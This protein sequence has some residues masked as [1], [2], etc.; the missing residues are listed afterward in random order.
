MGVTI[1]SKNQSIALSYFGFYRLRKKVAELINEDIA[2]HY[3]ELGSLHIFPTT[4]EEDRYWEEYDERTKSIV[5]EC[6]KN[7]WKVFDFLYESDTV[8]S[9]SYGTCKQILNVICEYDDDVVYGYRGR[10]D[11]AKMKDFKSLL[12]DCVNSKCKMTWF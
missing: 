2:K 9:V 3:E 10:P 5:S 11:G 4:D 7:I 8:G 1:H 6:P 12:K